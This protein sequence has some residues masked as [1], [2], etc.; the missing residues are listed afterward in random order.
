VEIG[1]AISTDPRLLLLD[2]PTSGLSTEESR[3]VAALV[4]NLK[5]LC[6]I[7]L[8]EHKM[9]VVMGVADRVTVFAEG[10]IFAE[11]TPEEISGNRAV[12]DIYL[13]RSDAHRR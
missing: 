8:V 7:V 10:R 11:G 3:E 1:I 9:D 12:Q 13:G 4:R 2:E 6:T 5:Q